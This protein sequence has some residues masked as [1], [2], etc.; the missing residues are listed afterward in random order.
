MCKSDKG[1]TAIDTHVDDG[2]G[3]CLS[4]EEELKL[5][6]GIQKFYKIKE[7]DTSKPFKVLGILVT[8]DAHH[9]T[10]KLSQAKYI[11]SILHKFDMTDCNPVLTP[12][13]KGSHLQGEGSAV[14]EDEKC[15]QAL[16]S[17]LSYAAMSTH[18]D[19]G[20][21]TQYLSQ[22]NKG[23]TQCDW[24]MAKRVLPYLKGMKDLGIVYRRSP[25]PGGVS[26]ADHVTLWGYCDTNYAEDPR[27]QKSASGFI[28]TGAPRPGGTG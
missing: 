27:D 2:M 4:K 25:K 8:R 7:K 26:Q 17:S 9:G 12:V 5:K 11:D 23:L 6:A 22:L 24:N 14:Y 16:T 28:A 18:L 21:I 15:Y 13:D 1:I 10:L 19:I 3:I 20:Y